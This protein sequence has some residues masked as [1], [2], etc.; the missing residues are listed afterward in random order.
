MKSETKNIL[1]IGLKN[2]QQRIDAEITE[3]KNNW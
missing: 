2:T 3:A 1:E